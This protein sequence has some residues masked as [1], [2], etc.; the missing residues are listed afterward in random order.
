MQTEHKVSLIINKMSLTSPVKDSIDMI[1]NDSTVDM[2]N[3]V[4]QKLN[5]VKFQAKK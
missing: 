3:N 1:F 4:E 2:K 5:P